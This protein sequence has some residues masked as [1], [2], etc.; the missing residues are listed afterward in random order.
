[1]RYDSQIQ[2]FKGTGREDIRKEIEFMGMEFESC[3]KRETVP[4]FVVPSS[5]YQ[6]IELDSMP[7]FC[8]YIHIQAYMHTYIHI[9]IFTSRNSSNNSTKVFLRVCTE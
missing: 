3:R 5:K 2:V 9:H 1:M 6:E 8:I 7:H 4:G